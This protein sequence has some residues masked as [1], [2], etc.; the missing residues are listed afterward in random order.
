MR[1][2]WANEKV[3]QVLLP[4][5]YEL[6]DCL[7]TEV[8]RMNKALIATGVKDLFSGAKKHEL[9][10]ITFVVNSYMR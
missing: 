8:D 9:A 6:V 7:V 4:H 1:R 2:V 5:R 10:R 3:S